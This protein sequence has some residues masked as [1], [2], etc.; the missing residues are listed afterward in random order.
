MTREEA[1]EI[2]RT[3]QQMSERPARDIN[4]IREALRIV[5]SAWAV[6]TPAPPEE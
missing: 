5:G 4:K 1:L 6:P 3:A 2:L